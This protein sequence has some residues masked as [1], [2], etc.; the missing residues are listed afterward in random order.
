MGVGDLVS[1]LTASG[2]TLAQLKDDEAFFSVDEFGPFAVRMR[3]GRALVPLGGFRVVPQW[4]KSR[5]ALI[6][7]AALELIDRYFAE[8]NNCKDPE[9]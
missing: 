4:Q 2:G 1:R 7:T 9:Y 3:G 6:V 8:H 5:G